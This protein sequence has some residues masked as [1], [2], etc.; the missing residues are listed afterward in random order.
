MEGKILKWSYKGLNTVCDYVLYILDLGTKGNK[1]VYF[2]TIETGNSTLKQAQENWS[3]HL[4]ADITFET[5]TKAFNNI[6]TIAPVVYK[7][8]NNFKLLPRRTVH[9]KLLFKMGISKTPNLFSA[10]Q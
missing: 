6:K 4:N 5:V 3:K 10:K 9:N 8:F 1:H 2:S 7:H